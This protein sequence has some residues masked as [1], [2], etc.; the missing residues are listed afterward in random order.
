M[1]DSIALILTFLPVHFAVMVSPGPNFILLSTTALSTGRKDALRAAFGIAVGSLIWMLAAAIGVSAL[2]EA[3]PALG[4]ALKVVG[5]LYLV[6]LGYKLWVSRGLAGNGILS[7]EARKNDSFR[8][9]LI[10]NLTNPK[11]AAYFGSVFAV[12]LTGEVSPLALAALIPALFVMSIAWYAALATTF[13]STAVR[14]PYLK[15]SRLINRI[16][17]TLLVALGVKMV[18]SASTN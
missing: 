3:L 17:G 10:S 7:G 9:G 15:Y 2:L 8:R 11:S 12:F 1:T 16:S 5:G 4:V 14:K 13:S 6:Y 18:G